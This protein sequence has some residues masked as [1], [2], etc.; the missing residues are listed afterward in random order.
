MTQRASINV[1]IDPDAVSA[2]KINLDDALAPPSMR[3]RRRQWRFGHIPRRHGGPNLDRRK[4][5]YAR[6]TVFAKLLAP[7]E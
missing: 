5:R 6:L 2:T 3:W 1:V 4:R 7:A